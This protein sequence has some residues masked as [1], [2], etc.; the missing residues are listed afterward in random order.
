[1]LFKGTEVVRGIVFWKDTFRIIERNGI[2]ESTF[3]INIVQQNI[4]LWLDIA[5]ENSVA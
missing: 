5:S 3:I 1:M 2:I 4:V